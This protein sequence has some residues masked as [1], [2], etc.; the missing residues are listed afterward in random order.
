LA[1][2]TGA[3]IPITAGAVFASGTFGAFASPIGDTTITTA[4]IMEMSIIDYAKYKLK[5]AFIA[6]ALTV[7][8]YLLASFLL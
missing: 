3:S 2:A 6:A 8:A 1:A 5:I 4:S 7:I